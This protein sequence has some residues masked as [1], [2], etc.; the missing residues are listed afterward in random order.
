MVKLTEE[1]VKS[2]ENEVVF[3]ATASKEGIPNVSAMKAVK[4]LD[5]EKGIVLIADN[6]MNKTLKNILENPKVALTTA[7]C[8]EISF[9]S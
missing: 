9:K 3:L 6:Y 5:S 8:R 4:V 2:L 1:M 7:N